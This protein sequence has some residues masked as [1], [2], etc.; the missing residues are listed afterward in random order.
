MYRLTLHTRRCPTCSAYEE[1]T[2]PTASRGGCWP[3][4]LRLLSIKAVERFLGVQYAS[5]RLNVG[6][7]AVYPEE[8]KT[9]SMVVI[10]PILLAPFWPYRI[11]LVNQ[12]A[13]DLL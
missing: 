12:Y 10:P 3:G 11:H 1:Y 13:N 8:P 9:L 5:D 7:V 6:K 4:P 2:C